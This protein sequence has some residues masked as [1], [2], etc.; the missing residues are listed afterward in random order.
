[1]S[2]GAEDS[3][4]GF[5]RVVFF[6]DAVF[7]I[8]ITL[9]VLPLTAEFEVPEDTASL[10]HE[11]AELWPKIVTFGVSFLVVGQFWMA[12]HRVFSRIARAD[13]G[14]LA[15]NLLFL[16]TVS[17]MPF[18]AAVLGAFELDEDALVRV[19][20]AASLTV[21]SIV[22]TVVWL[23]AQR[24]GLLRPAVTPAKASEVMAGSLTTDAVFVVS[25]AAAYFSFLAAVL[26]WVVL[27]PIARRLIG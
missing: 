5:E 12:H 18:P 8:V 16:L 7:A 17:F 23:Y 26:C 1:V 2:D 19:F 4:L 22:L 13:S 21:V 20:Y 25:I 11:L 27:M 6:S 24:R 9:L 10:A 15:L 14:L 3:S